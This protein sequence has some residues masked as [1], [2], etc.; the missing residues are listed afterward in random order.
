MLKFSD[1]LGKWPSFLST[2]SINSQRLYTNGK[3]NGEFYR[4]PTSCSGPEWLNDDVADTEWEIKV[5]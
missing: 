4:R 5:T 3:Q 1:D 2:V